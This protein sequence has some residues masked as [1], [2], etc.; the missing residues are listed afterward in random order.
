MYRKI[1][2]GHANTNSTVG[3][4]HRKSACHI[5]QTCIVQTLNCYLTT[6]LSSTGT[7]LLCRQRSLI[8][9][10]RQHLAVA[11]Y[12]RHHT[13]QS[14]ARSACL[15][16]GSF[17]CACCYGHMVD[18]I[19]ACDIDLAAGDMRAF[20]HSHHRIGIKISYINRCTY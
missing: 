11:A 9:N 16:R 1:I 10:Y 5:H 15:T 18:S 8:V 7:V 17:T 20:T 19:C 12:H 4:G 3:M 13:V 14:N 6:G 2:H